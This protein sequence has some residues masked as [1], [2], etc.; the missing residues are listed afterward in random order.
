MGNNVELLSSLPP[1]HTLQTVEEVFL[2]KETDNTDNAL[3]RTPAMV[4]FMSLHLMM[5]FWAYCAAVS[6]EAFLLPGL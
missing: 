5:F 2:A 4:I 6:L 3:Q 1:T